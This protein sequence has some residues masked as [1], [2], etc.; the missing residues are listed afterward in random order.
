KE[1]LKKTEKEL[2]HSKK[3]KEAMVSQSQSLK[4][5]YDRLLE[6]HRLLQVKV[7]KG[8]GDKKAD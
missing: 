5:E 8:E 1:K 6:E 7:S 4:N 2:E 3:D